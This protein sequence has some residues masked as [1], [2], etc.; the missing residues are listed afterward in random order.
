VLRYFIA[1]VFASIGAMRIP[2]FDRVGGGGRRDN[3]TGAVLA[4]LCALGAAF[5]V[6]ELAKGAFAL[7]GNARAVAAGTV[8]NAN[9]EARAA[10]AQRHRVV[11]FIPP[12]QPD[13]D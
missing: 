8:R 11:N 7:A 9:R 6:W 3:S 1:Q 10:I 12:A 13:I 5:L 2:F 4:V